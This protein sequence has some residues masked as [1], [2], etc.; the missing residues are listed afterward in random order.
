MTLG[1]VER[2]QIQRN[3][4]GLGAALGR[5]ACHPRRPVVGAD[6]AEANRTLTPE[7]KRILYGNVTI[8]PPCGSKQTEGLPEYSFLGAFSLLMKVAESSREATAANP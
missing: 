7:M 8:E 3:A 6:H 5:R 1:Y 4:I 2:V